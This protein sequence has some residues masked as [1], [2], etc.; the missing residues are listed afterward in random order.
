MSGL[1]NC[2]VLM[3]TVRSLVFS[4]G[5]VGFWANGPLCLAAFRAS[6]PACRCLPPFPLVMPKPWAQRS[7]KMGACTTK[8]RKVASAG[9]G[10]CRQD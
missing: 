2:M 5:L 8:E 7:R 10:D 6:G 1:M 4:R 9:V 3:K